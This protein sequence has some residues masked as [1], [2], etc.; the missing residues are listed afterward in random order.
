MSQ[1]PQR[2]KVLVIH[3]HVLVYRKPMEI[4][5]YGDFPRNIERLDKTFREKTLSINL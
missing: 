1:L 2:N 5:I 3:V 4:K